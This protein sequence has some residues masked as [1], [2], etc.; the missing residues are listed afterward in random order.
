MGFFIYSN[1]QIF[2]IMMKKIV[3]TE[4][5]R[6][7]NLIKHIT[8]QNFN[9]DF[10]SLQGGR[11]SVWT[12][13]GE[14]SINH[15][16]DYL[17]DIDT[18]RVKDKPPKSNAGYGNQRGGFKAKDLDINNRKDRL[19]IIKRLLKG[20]KTN[21]ATPETLDKIRNVIGGDDIINGLRLNLTLNLNDDFDIELVYFLLQEG[22]FN[23]RHWLSKSKTFMNNIEL[24]D[25][26]TYVYNRRTN[27]FDYKKT[28]LK[29]KKNK[30]PMLDE[31]VDFIRKNH[32]KMYDE[33]LK[34][35]I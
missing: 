33:H 28:Y 1:S 29:F 16:T 20:H 7:K 23:N 13:D 34:S 4:I 18:S 14:V 25:Y 15:N 31:F 35:V 22:K 11:Y 8:E 2:I 12:K 17:S 5:E 32:E 27:D 6:V 19:I 3:L 9:N 10:G 24:S 30:T 21:K 26:D